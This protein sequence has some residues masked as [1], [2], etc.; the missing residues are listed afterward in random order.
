MVQLSDRA[1]L[2]LK[3]R[4]LALIAFAIGSTLIAATPNVAGRLCLDGAP[5]RDSTCSQSVDAA[6]VARSYTFVPSSTSIHHLSVLAPGANAIS[7]ANADGFE[8]RVSGHGLPRR[9]GANV[10]IAGE[11]GNW[12]LSLAHKQVGVAIP[13]R[14]R[15]GTY[16]LTVD[17][18]HFVRARKNVIV[19]QHRVV[20]VELEPLPTLSGTVRSLSTGKQVAGARISTDDGAAEAVISDY[21]GRF[22]LEV[23]PETWPSKLIVNAVGYAE[24]SITV[25]AE[26]KSAALPRIDL[27]PA[28]TIVV[29]LTQPPQL[30]VREVELQKLPHEKRIIGVSKGTQPVPAGVAKTTIRFENVE[31]G[32]Y[33]VVAK[34]ESPWKQ[35]GDVVAVDQGETATVSQTIE[36]FE[37]TV[38]TRMLGA[39][40]AKA[41]VDLRNNDGHWTARFE[42]DDEG[43][44]TITLWQGGDITSS[45]RGPN[46]NSFIE[47]RRLEDGEDV[48]WVIDVPA[49]EITGTVLDEKS[50]DPLPAAQVHLSVVS[51]DGYQQSMS[52]TADDRGRFR[53][54][55]G[56]SSSTTTP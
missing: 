41:K 52:T 17:T 6:D 22:S 19:G 25:P 48:E 16:A 40:I 4:L 24:T 37:L 44:T 9:A 2:L 12:R 28:G 34:G 8:L 55:R 26:R 54:Q 18:R 1:R 49:R 20:A 35:R 36:P 46:I 51:D 23:D 56:S 39:P 30:D 50:G 53:E 32:L 5:C 3:L 10:T 13:I 27:S 21:E 14:L 31:P 33:A 29:E 43:E 45:V 38:R 11:G 15:K 7:C 42:T 47:R